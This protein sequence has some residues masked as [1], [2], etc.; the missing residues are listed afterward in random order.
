MNTYK[1]TRKFNRRIMVDFVKAEGMITAL[2]RTIRE[3]HG[4]LDGVTEYHPDFD[5]YYP[6]TY[7]YRIATAKCNGTWYSSVKA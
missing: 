7:N 3:D 5:D 4:S 1:V 2:V 6:Y